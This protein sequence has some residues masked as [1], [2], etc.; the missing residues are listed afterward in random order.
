MSTPAESPNAVDGHGRKTGEWTY[1]DTD[2]S[3][4]KTTTHRPRPPRG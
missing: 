2:G 1:Y 4:R 3:I